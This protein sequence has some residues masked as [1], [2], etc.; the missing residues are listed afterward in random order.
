MSEMNEAQRYRLW[1][2]RHWRSGGWSP[3]QNR[4][5]TKKGATAIAKLIKDGLLE[6]DPE[7]AMCRLTEAGHR[8][9]GEALR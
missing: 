1:V 4:L 8:A 6:R 5:R 2:L 3:V 7:Y 9:V